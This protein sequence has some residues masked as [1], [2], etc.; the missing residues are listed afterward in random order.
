M[1]APF[2]YTVWPKLPFAYSGLAQL[3]PKCAQKY[4]KLSKK[5]EIHRKPEGLEKGRFTGEIPYFLRFRCSRGFLHTV[6]VAGSNP[7]SPT[8]LFLENQLNY[9]PLLGSRNL[10]SFK[11]VY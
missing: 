4:R 9:C 3:C 6:E 5:I 1:P 7:A 2:E 11:Q 10:F 8:N